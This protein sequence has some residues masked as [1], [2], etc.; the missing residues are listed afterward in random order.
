MKKWTKAALLT[1]CACCIAGAAL[2]L[3]VSAYTLYGNSIVPESGNH[4]GE[5]HGDDT[6]K[7]S[8][9]RSGGSNAKD[10]F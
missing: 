1:G 10:T 4:S 5:Y 3:C 8:L 7:A 6:V 2:I 9:K